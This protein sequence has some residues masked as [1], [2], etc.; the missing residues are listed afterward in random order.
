MGA[1]GRPKGAKSEPKDN[2]NA[3]KSRPSEK[4]AKRSPK[5][6]SP[7]RQKADNLHVAPDHFGSHF[8][9]K[10]DEKIDAKIDAEKVMNFM[11][12]PCEI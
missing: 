5:R 10:I 12:N 1:K 6:E 8:P 11:K 9:S 3:S 2:Q 4:V 7:W